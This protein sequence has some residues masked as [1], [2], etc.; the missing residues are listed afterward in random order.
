MC[1]H[2]NIAPLKIYISQ[3]A[4]L[5]NILKCNPVDKMVLPDTSP[6]RCL[7]LK[8]I[9]LT[10]MDKTRIMSEIKLTDNH[11]DFAQELLKK[12]FPHISGLQSTCEASETACNVY[13]F[14]DNSFTGKPL[15][16]GLEHRMC[17]QNFKCSIFNTRL[18]TKQ[19]S[20]Y[21]QT[22]LGQVL[23]KWAIHS[24]KHESSPS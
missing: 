16:C 22:C 17:T 8:R 11:I 9:D 15:D 13:I 7:S 12:Q 4:P 14:A 5:P 20:S 1:L 23:L 18:L 10:E 19:Q 21:S 24:A 3:Y 2:T 6:N